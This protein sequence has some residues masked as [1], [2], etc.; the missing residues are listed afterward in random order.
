MTPQEL[1]SATITKRERTPIENVAVRISDIQVNEDQPSYFIGNRLDNNEPIRV[2][3]MTV[4]EAVDSNKRKDANQGD[5]ERLTNYF[6]EKFVSGTHTRPTPNKFADPAAK[7]HVQPGGVVLFE[8][9][10]KN[11]DGSYRA[12]WANTV[13]PSPDSEVMIAL[14]HL[15][16]RDENPAQKQKAT[17]RATIINPEAA[18]NLQG[19]DR[20][21]TIYAMM[22]DKDSKGNPRSPAP[23]LRL[24]LSDGSLAHAV[25]PAMTETIIKKD[26]TSG[27]DKKL[28]VVMSPDKA[29]EKLLNDPEIGKTQNG[30]LVK[31][32]LSG[33]TGKP[34]EWGTTVSE[35]GKKTLERL[36]EN[37]GN[38][39]TP[40]MAIPGQRI[41]AG[42]QAAASM[43]KRA[44]S[45]NSPMGRLLNSVE[46]NTVEVNGEPVK[47]TQPTYA[48]AVISVLRHQDT[49]APFL[50]DV[51]TTSPWPKFA[52][53]ADI[54]L[55]KSAQLTAERIQDIPDA[56]LDTGI[57]EDDLDSSM[58][59][60][61]MD[62]EPYL[63]M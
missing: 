43:V 42:N 21:N 54:D 30:R 49:K 39:T 34:A 17:V 3:L 2:R 45:P 41:Y 53:L 32:A 46:N 61:A 31:A 40:V 38:G 23:V 11:D 22:M 5:I 28:S 26:F 59:H 58:A 1:N 55:G 25:I 24:T 19:A 57:S 20:L 60:A 35:N 6:T 48:E 33:I 37:V 9:A 14:V 10:T 36:A 8:R 51:Y 29:I 56:A 18:V 4:A 15:D 63:G 7:E 47:T 62:D 13:A 44:T 16:A 27:L 12:Q 50:R 52:T